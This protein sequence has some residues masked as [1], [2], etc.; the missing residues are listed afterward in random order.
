[1]PAFVLSDVR[2]FVKPLLNCQPGKR[3]P[4]AYNDLYH[5]LAFQS[6]YN[7]LA[8]GPEAQLTINPGVIVTAVRGF[9]PPYTFGA[10]FKFWS[11][12]TNLYDCT[13]LHLGQH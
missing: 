10:A 1:M 2:G 3:S 6:M 8:I 13:F 5:V 7:P 9:V 11:Y 4:L 12:I